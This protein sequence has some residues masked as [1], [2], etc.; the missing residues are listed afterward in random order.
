MSRAITA[1]LKSGQESDIAH[2][3][4]IRVRAMAHDFAADA[5]VEIEAGHGPLLANLSDAFRVRSSTPSKGALLISISV[6]PSRLAAHKGQKRVF[7]LEIRT[8]RRTAIVSGRLREKAGYGLAGPVIQGHYALPD[9]EDVWVAAGVFAQPSVR[10]TFHPVPHQFKNDEAN[11]EKD[12]NGACRRE[13]TEMVGG[14]GP[15]LDAHGGSA[16]QDFYPACVPAAW[17]RLF[18]AYRL[19]HN[20][21][22]PESAE[23]RRW[24]IGTPTNPNPDPDEDGDWFSTWSIAGT[25]A[26]ARFDPLRVEDWRDGAARPVDPEVVP[27]EFN[28]TIVDSA[29]KIDERADRID[30]A[31]KALVSGPGASP[32]GPVWIAHDGHAWNIVGVETAGYWSHAQNNDANCLSDWCEWDRSDWRAREKTLADPHPIFWIGYLRGCELKPVEKRQGSITMWGSGGTKD[33]V[34]FI[35]LPASAPA[36]IDWTPHTKAPAGYVWM[37]KDVALTLDGFPRSVTTGTWD[38]ELGYRIPLPP[39]HFGECTCRSEG[40][41]PSCRVRLQLPFWVHNTTLDELRTYKVSLLFWTHQ[42]R[43]QSIAATLPAAGTAPGFAADVP[44][45]YGNMPGPRPNEPFQILAAPDP[46]PDPGAVPKPWNCRPIAWYVD[47]RKDQ[48]HPWSTHGIRL[49]LTCLD[50]CA[51]QDVKQ[52]WFRTRHEPV[53]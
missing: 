51:V 9:S 20:T 3:S 42:Q 27:F 4:G 33:H 49:V 39:R 40:G 22:A 8:G 37:A 16:P 50:T 26:E 29:T 47:L 23:R 32:G 7:F 11:L 45:D 43:W 10:R 12:Q 13:G 48:L 44:G 15:C 14:Q 19:V 2:P 21:T 34:R 38:D 6:D 18:G 36:S 46:D 30:G 41:C 24:A 5:E 1:V 17:A 28:P 25:P 31:L 52:L 35:E 53:G